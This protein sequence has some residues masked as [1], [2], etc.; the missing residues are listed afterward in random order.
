MRKFYLFL[1]TLL[2]TGLSLYAQQITVKGIVKDSEELGILGVNVLNMSTKSGVITDVDGAYE[3][4]AQKGDNLQF[5]YIGMKSVTLKVTG[6]KLNVKMEE[7]SQVLNE[8]VAIGYGTSTKKDLTGSVASLKLENSPI[9]TLPN[10]NVL[11]SLKGSLP[12]V[13]IGLATSAGGTPSFSIRG[14][15]SISAGSSPLLVVDG[16]IGGD[17]SQINP[18]DIASIDV[19]KDASSAAV[20]GSRA[21]NGVI[22]VTTKRGKSEKPQFNL[23][24]NYGI[25]SWTRKPNMMNADQYLKYRKEYYAAEGYTGKDLEPEFFLKPKEWDAYQAGSSYNWLDEVSQVGTTEN[26][27]FSVSGAN[28]NF[29]Y[30][31]SANHYS[32]EGIMLGDNFKRNSIL[33]KLEAQLSKYIKAGINV[34]GNIRDYSGVGPDMYLATYVGPLGFMN[35]TEAGYENWLERY[36]GGNTTWANPLWNSYGVDDSD[37][38]YGAS[39][40]AF[41]EIKLPWIEGLSWHVNAAYNLSQTKQAQFNHETHYVNTLKLSEMQNPSAFLKNANGYS[42]SDNASSWLINHILNYNRTFGDHKVDFTFMS[43]RQRHY[44]DGVKATGSDFE[45]AGTTVLGYNSLELGNQEKRKIDTYKTQSSE[46]AYM[47]RLNYVYKNRYH[48]SGS[49]RRDGFSAFSEGYKFGDFFSTAL[50]WTLTEEEFM[51]NKVLN[52]LKVR[53]SYG[54]NGN[55]SIDSYSTFPTVGIG[56]YIFDKTVVNTLYQNK[57]ANKNLGWE[58]TQAVNLGFDFGLFKDRISGNVEYYQS[59]TKDLLVTRRLPAT[60][61][62]TSILDN[63]GKISNWGLEI[64]LKSKNIVTKD[65]SWETGLSFWMNRN[66]VKSLYGID[67]DGDG[68]EDD[69]LSNGWFIGKPLGSIY[70]YTVDGIVQTEDTEYCAQYNAKPGDV[71]FVDISGPDGVPD[72]KIDATYDRSIIGYST[73]NFKMNMSQTLTYKNLQLYFTLDYINGGGNRYLSNNEKGFNPNALP[74]ANWINESFWTPDNP[75]NVSPRANYNNSRGWGFYQS[76]EFLRL[77]DITLSYS[78]DQK[79]LDKLKVLKSAKVF[80]SGKNLL[81]ITD[82]RGLDP[83][84]GQRI[85]EGSPSFKVISIGANVSF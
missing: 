85:G 22:I 26:Y 36:P 63:M 3:I 76:R 6:P 42:R 59:T 74:N 44:T 17:F 18:M 61:G 69:D 71:K 2:L 32:Q 77:Q 12:G 72:G 47:T 5:S 64:S 68:R 14:Q 15:N 41:A 25:N 33:A 55:P 65:F 35:S 24:L 37:I 84:S 40:K 8:V 13:N 83:E 34:S 20:Y 30:Y 1:C 51:K 73:P 82:W 38:R 75:S 27:Q 19:L 45:Q 80:I 11:E 23:N 66:K 53:L 4:K 78:L 9:A 31:V 57:L 39:L 46:L 60:T 7:D 79:M 28:D 52:Y 58:R 62:Y 81:T 21:A 16:I 70:S 56:S 49:Y 67:A 48:V 43:E 54:E 29:N 10:S 50:A